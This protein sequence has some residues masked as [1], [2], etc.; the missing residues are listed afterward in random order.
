MTHH[1][2]EQ[3]HEHADGEISLIRRGVSTLVNGVMSG[4]EIAVET[5]GTIVGRSLRAAG[6]GV[7]GLVRG[8]FPRS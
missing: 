4:A 7:R 8:L 5:G 1:S 6:K 2:A 3:A